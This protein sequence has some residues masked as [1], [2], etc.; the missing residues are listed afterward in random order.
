MVTEHANTASAV[1]SGQAPL[2]AC[3]AAKNAEEETRHGGPG[4]A[5]TRASSD[6]D[7]RALTSSIRLQSD[8]LH[9]TR[10][11]TVHLYRAGDGSENTLTHD[12]TLVGGGWGHCDSFRDVTPDTEE[13]TR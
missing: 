1:V 13:V 4:L 12:T 9:Y 3:V 8:C 5:K 2:A 7:T 10:A 11:D 6:P